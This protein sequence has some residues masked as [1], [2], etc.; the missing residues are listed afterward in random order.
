MKNIVFDDKKLFSTY[1]IRQIEQY[2]LL[3]LLS[4]IVLQVLGLSKKLEKNKKH[5]SP[6]YQRG[7]W[8]KMKKKDS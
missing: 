7:S 8:K 4:N 5:K 1:I 3:P 2:L 6:L